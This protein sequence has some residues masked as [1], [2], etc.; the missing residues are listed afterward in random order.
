M[1]LYN[2]SSS[3]FSMIARYA[4]LEAGVV[5]ENRL[6]DIHIAKEQLSPW[7]LAINPAMTVPSL[8]DGLQSWLDSRAILAYA[9][10]A[11]ADNWLDADA[12]LRP[13]IREIVQAHY[14][15]SV[16]RFTFGKALVSIPPLRLIVPMMLRNI[17]KKLETDLTTSS[18]PIATQA[19]IDINSKRLA[20][21]TTGNRLDK[22]D[23][24]RD[25][26]KDFL[27][28]LPSPGLFLLGEKPSAADI[29]LVVLLGRLKMIGEYSLVPQK[30]ELA[31]WFLHMQ[32]RQAYKEADI[33][34]N[35][36][37]FRILFNRH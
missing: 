17:I 18:N 1:I 16:E 10:T 36:N 6:M 32:T 20:Y 33:W 3:Y 7:Y 23:I 12:A 22:L 29:L 11:A 5:F 37:P 14:L 13:C 9:A 4:L 24:E 15:I 2:A 34:T 31:R 19:K 25:K 27:S 21:F 30:S 8:T 28:T 26:I 35:F